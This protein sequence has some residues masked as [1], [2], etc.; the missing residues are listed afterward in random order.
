VWIDML[1][2]AFDPILRVLGPNLV[3]D[4]SD[5]YS[6]GWNSRLEVTVPED[7]EVLIVAG[8]YY[9]EGQGDFRLRVSVDPPPLEVNSGGGGGE[10][11][12]GERV[13]TDLLEGLVA[14][15]SL[16]LPMGAE[17]EGTLTD[18]DRVL[19][20]EHRAQAWTF[21]GE[22]G[23]AVI[24]EVSAEDF[25]PVIY[26]AGPGVGNP[27]TDD[28]GGDGLNARLVLVLPETGTYTVVVGALSEGTGSFRIRAL[29]QVG[30]G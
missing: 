23:Q 17:V 6:E 8:A 20:D 29:R 1:S 9:A 21:R 7:G 3:E 12:V 24:F 22:A 14:D 19:S 30:A 28:D 25:D 5:D 15:P 11:S 26:L 2:D 27:L 18:D 4:Q 13:D 10:A 16:V